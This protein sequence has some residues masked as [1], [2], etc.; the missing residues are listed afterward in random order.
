[1]SWPTPT[2]LAYQLGP[3]RDRG[4]DLADALGVASKCSQRHVAVLG[5]EHHV[6][7]GGDLG[8]RELTRVGAGARGTVVQ[9]T[10]CSSVAPGMKAGAFEAED[11]EDEGKREDGLRALDGS[12]DIRLG[13]ALGES[14][15]GK[16][17]ARDAEQNQ[18]ESD[19]GGED[20]CSTVELDDGL[21][22]VLPLLLQGFDRDDWTQATPL[23]GRDGGA[24]DGDVPRKGS[25]AGA[26]HMFAQGWS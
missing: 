6:L 11:L 8:G 4:E 10:G 7:D 22:Q 20:A 5:C 23:P 9:G 1:M 19:H 24:W 17:E 3:G 18:Q 16:A 2:A 26:E 14:S 25:G 12:G 21:K 15:A 13:R